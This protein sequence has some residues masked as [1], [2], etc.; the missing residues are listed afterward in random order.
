LGITFLW[1]QWE[2]TAQAVQAAAL[3]QLGDNRPYKEMGWGPV[4]YRWVVA[5]VSFQ[6]W[7]IRS[8]FVYNLLYPVFKWAIGRYAPI[9]FGLLFLMWVSFTTLPLIEGQGLFFFSV[10]IWLYKQNYPLEKTPDWFSYF[11]A[12]LIFIGLV[13]IKTF[14]AFEL[15][16]QNPLSK[17]VFSLFHV[18]S[19]S[20]GVLAIWFSGDKLVKWAMHQ[21]WFV[22]ATSFSFIIY[23]LHVPLLPYVNQ[24]FFRYLNHIPN[25]RLITYIL[26]PTLVLFFC[27]LTGALLRRA[28]PK[29]YGLAT[30]GRGF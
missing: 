26:A 16:E 18:A 24:I 30:G 25:Y 4:L 3:D 10:G 8:L 19:V 1:Q 23:A 14:M 22:W 20:A 6:L 7:F 17:A 9:W 29:T 11:L 28:I 21:K 15:E 27:I 13:V 2:V 12:W 5:P